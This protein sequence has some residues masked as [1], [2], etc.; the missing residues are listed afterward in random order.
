MGCVAAS[1]AAVRQRLIAK[2][3]VVGTN[4]VTGKR[5]KTKRVVGKSCRVTLKRVVTHG[6]VSAAAIA[7]GAVCM[8]ERIRADGHISAVKAVN[9]NDGA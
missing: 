9:P 4:G 8:L 6:V 5:L 1:G 7:A 3:R 2:G